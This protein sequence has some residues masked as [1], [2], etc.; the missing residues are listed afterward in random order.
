[1]FAQAPAAGATQS[2]VGASPTTSSGYDDDHDDDEYDDEYEDDHDDDDDDDD[3]DDEHEYEG[4][5]DD[6]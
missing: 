1:V 6:D 5:D 4:A 2:P 3:D